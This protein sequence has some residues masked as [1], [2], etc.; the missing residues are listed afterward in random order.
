MRGIFNRGK[1]RLPYAKQKKYGIL[2]KK[3][4]TGVKQFAAILLAVLLLTGCASP[5]PPA[6]SLPESPY[7]PQDFQQT[8]GFLSCAAGAAAVGIDV[9]SHQGSIDWEQV[10]AAGVRYAFVRLGYRGYSNGALNT[11]ELAR[12]NLAGAKAAGLLVGAY[13]FSQAGS[14]EEAR[15][16]AAWAL[17]VLEDFALDLPLVYDWEYVSDTARTASVDRDALTQCTLAFCAAAEEAG[18][19]AMIYFNT[20]QGRDLLEL[21]QLEQY[22]W[23]LAKYD[24]QAAFLCRT[25]MWQY[26]NTGTV[27]GIQGNVDINLMFTDFGLGQAVFGTVE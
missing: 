12:E 4:V 15:E 21:E 11:D 8:D 5:Q 19:E 7:T 9:S 6:W 16:E 3:G 23:W 26:T 24:L 18:L 13:W 25:D 2:S 17:G 10:A 20:S 14:V 27:A 22:P 1:G